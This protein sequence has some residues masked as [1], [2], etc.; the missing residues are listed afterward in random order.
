MAADDRDTG[1]DGPGGGHGGGA[2]G[3]PVRGSATGGWIGSVV[4]DVVW[5]PT[6]G[7]ARRLPP[8][9][10][11]AGGGAAAPRAVLGGVC[12]RIAARRGAEVRRVR[13]LFVLTLAPAVLY[14][15]FWLVRA[16]G[17]P[18]VHGRE[19]ANRQLF[20]GV[21]VI[22]IALTT[23]T[24]LEAASL[25]PF[26]DS[27]LLRDPSPADPGAQ[28]RFRGSPVPVVPE[29]G[30]LLMAVH[31][32]VG[33]AL[34][35]PLF[36]LP[37]SPLLT[38]R[39]M[40]LAT[41]VLHL[42]VPTFQALVMPFESV[43]LLAYLVVLYALAAQYERRIVYGVGACSVLMVIACA[44]IPGARAGEALWS[45]LLLVAALFLGA[46]A[47]LR[48]PATATYIARPG[49]VA[50]RRTS[51]PVIDGVID[52]VWGAPVR[53]PGGPLRL[54]GGPRR[55]LRGRAVA[56]VC[57]ALSRGSR[58]ALIALRAAFVLLLPLGVPAYA[59]L[60]LVLPRED[61]PIPE[62]DGGGPVPL[63]GR[64]IAAWGLLATVSGGLAAL[65]A[66]QL[67]FFHGVPVTASVL[68]GCAAGLPF[69]LLPYAPL[70]T[71]RL[72][73]GAVFAILIAV[74]TAGSPPTDLWPWPV[75]ALLALPVVLYAVAA[76]HPGWTTVGVGVVT[77]GMDTVAASVIAGTPVAQ[78]A[79]LAAVVAGVLLLGYNVGGRRAAQ[80]RLARESALRREDRARQAVLEER[81]RIARE[82][83]DV[84]SHHMSMI[85][86]QAEAAPYK[87]PEMGPGATDSLHAI[88]DAAR[89]AL[90]EMRRV[91]GLLR[92]E[93]ER[94]ERAPQPGLA[95]L[96]DLL[97]GARQAGMAVTVAE[98]ADPA[99]LPG[100]VDLSA[101]RIVQESLSN[102]GRHAPGAA[103]SV[104]LLRT[105]DL[106]TVRVVNGPRPGDAR[107]GATPGLG[108]GGHGLVGMRER[109]AML[110]GRLR[111]APLPDGGFEVTADLPLG[112]EQ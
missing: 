32:S 49:D 29:V 47:R 54:L 80:R 98:R 99:G 6:G 21:V 27:G 70:L 8:P 44:T 81:S 31:L 30:G 60:W 56:G 82:L 13:L 93:G 103:V 86:I 106:L 9:P 18:V 111:A 102:A 38:W 50:G 108:S 36:L 64:E 87:Y 39:L 26:A 88:R 112:D 72:T 77:A 58:G 100:A 62:D 89:D 10:E 104:S 15:V 43:A 90:A 66:V 20:L 1:P 73:A 4:S 33:A 79:W 109:V 28:A 74:G 75:A 23:R 97:A 35:A 22:I 46:N 84:V 2:D 48:R 65:V 71:W 83:H 95:D 7:L 40:T 107:P 101:Y 96:D 91:V 61:E 24:E 105:G 25:T 68:L 69:A 53:R 67:V 45:V 3:T 110:G 94:P 63:S 12:A 76:A 55:P 14:P 34:G 19:L 11:G 52:A 78:S 17:R 59:V 37:A 92:D 85:A 41:L 5:R 51:V 42:L 16:A 57:R